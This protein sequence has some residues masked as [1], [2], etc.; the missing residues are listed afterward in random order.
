MPM[1]PSLTTGEVEIRKQLGG[2]PSTNILEK[3][4]SILKEIAILK[5]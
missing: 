2:H 4:Y 1:P 3:G 5:M